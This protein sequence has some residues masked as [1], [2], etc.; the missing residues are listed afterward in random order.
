MTACTPTA[1][2][3]WPTRSQRLGTV[4]VVAPHIEASAIGHA[5]T[6][7]RPLRMERLRDDVYEVDGTPTDCVN[8]AITQHPRRP[9]RP[10]RLRHQQGLQ[11]RRRRDVFGDRGGR[12]GRLAARDPEYR[13][14][15]RADRATYDFSP[16][17][18]A[19]AHDRGSRAR[20][21]SA[22]AHVHQHQRPVRHAAGASARPSRPSATTSPSSPSARTRAA[23]RTTGSRK[24]RTTGSRTTVPTTRR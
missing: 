13:G 17:A 4:I 23:V 22:G 21:R 20:A 3:R 5:L 7:R 18:D 9:A 11:P 6:L 15:A 24:G 8:V 16:A 1:S 10:R 2:M 19:A 14:V 12:D